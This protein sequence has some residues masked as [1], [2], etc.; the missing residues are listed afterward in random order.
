MG[1]KD[2]HRASL[3]TQFASWCAS[4]LL[5]PITFILIN[6]HTT[7]N[8]S[9]QCVKIWH[10]FGGCSVPAM[11]SGSTFLKLLGWSR[12]GDHISTSWQPWNSLYSIDLFKV[13]CGVCACMAHAGELL[14]GRQAPPCPTERKRT[15]FSSANWL[16][17]CT[18]LLLSTMP[19]T[20]RDLKTGHE[21][22]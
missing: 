11:G 21:L 4:Y 19:G 15:N 14:E 1:K 12:H 9:K 3:V 6:K 2:E 8:L 17:I 22:I 7:H 18:S 20:I 13:P 5:G 16:W 10:M